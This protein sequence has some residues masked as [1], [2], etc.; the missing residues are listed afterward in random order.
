MRPSGDAAA[1][2]EEPEEEVIRS[3]AQRRGM[4]KQAKTISRARQRWGA[5]AAGRPRGRGEGGGK[6]QHWAGGLLGAL[7][8]SFAACL[9]VLGS[10]KG[11]AAGDS[12]RAL[13]P[14]LSLHSAG[15]TA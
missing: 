6:G 14:S 9:L 3:S 10:R 2:A 5:A 12:D 1:A 8:C 7:F 11:D 13:A 15:S 4:P